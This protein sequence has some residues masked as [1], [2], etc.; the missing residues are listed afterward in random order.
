MSQVWNH[1]PTYVVLIVAV[2]ILL[3]VLHM[4]RDHFSSEFPPNANVQKTDAM[5]NSH[6]KQ[7]TNHVRPN[8]H[9]DAPPIQ[10]VKS[11]FRVNIWDSYIP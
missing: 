8:G 11:P 7:D 5:K 6:Y 2:V 9:F 1:V 3:G 4:T 10:G